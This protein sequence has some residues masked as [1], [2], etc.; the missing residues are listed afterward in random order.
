MTHEGEET[1]ADDDEKNAVKKTKHPISLVWCPIP[2][3]THVFPLIGHVGITN[4]EGWVNDFIGDGLV[5]QSSSNNLSFNKVMRVCT[6][7]NESCMKQGGVDLAIRRAMMHYTRTK[8][9]YNFFGQNCHDFVSTVLNLCEYHGKKNWHL[10]DVALLVW[11]VKGNGG[12]FLDWECVLYT[13]GPLAILLSISFLVGAF[14]QVLRV[15]LSVYVVIASWFLLYVYVFNKRR[16][17]GV[18]AEMIPFLRA[19]NINSDN[20]VDDEYVA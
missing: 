13:F 4:S 11:G 9:T 8:E 18:R 2:I 6:L 20:N 15:L 3:I 5:H 7:N 17:C 10:V 16:S 1:C 12:T 14:A 19:N